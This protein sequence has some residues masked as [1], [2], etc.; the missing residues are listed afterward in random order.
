VFCN[1]KKRAGEL[2]ANL[3]TRGFAAEALHGDMRQNERDAVMAKFRNGDISI[4]VATD[5]AARGIDVEKIE[6]VF[7]YDVPNDEEYYVHRIGRTGRAGETGAAYTFVSGRELMVLKDIQRFT[8]API[9]MIEPP[10]VYDIEENRAG[11]LLQRVSDTIE[12]DNYSQYTAYI[13]QIVEEVNSKYGNKQ[14][15]TTLDVAASLLKMLSKRAEKPKPSVT[16][17]NNRQIKS[18]GTH[19]RRSR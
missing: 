1:T 3:Q 17:M 18:T 2:A 19:Y 7:N 11:K 10:S 16:I 14:N 15:I 13:E 12:E 4:L 6:A 8:K 9:K 5:V